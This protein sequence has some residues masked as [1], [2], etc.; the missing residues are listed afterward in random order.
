M[1]LLCWNSPACPN[2]TQ[3]AFHLVLGC[4]GLILDLHWLLLL[5]Q[6]MHAPGA[7][8]LSIVIKEMSQMHYCQIRMT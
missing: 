6:Y 4:S 5:V 7:L 2:P 1:H 3:V 8:S